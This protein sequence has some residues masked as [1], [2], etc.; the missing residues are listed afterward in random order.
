MH[1]NLPGHWDRLAGRP[2]HRINAPEGIL[3]YPADSA[4]PRLPLVGLRAVV[5]NKL[6][7]RVRGKDGMV[8]LS[9]RPW[10]WPFG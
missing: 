9:S 5:R 8:S 6:D 2:P 7:L 1:A 10:W 4:F 3:V